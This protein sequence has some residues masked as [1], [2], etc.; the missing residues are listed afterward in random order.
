MNDFNPTQAAAMEI[1]ELALA[2]S[3][4]P[5]T[6]KVMTPLEDIVI[7]KDW[8]GDPALLAEHALTQCGYPVTWNVVKTLT[9]K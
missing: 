7:A 3:G 9:I 8:T 4:R 2:N 5:L 6:D 1:I